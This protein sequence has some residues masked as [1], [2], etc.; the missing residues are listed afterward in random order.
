MRRNDKIAGPIVAR[1]ACWRSYSWGMEMRRRA[2][3]QAAM[4]L[5]GLFLLGIGILL[6]GGGL[7][8]NAATDDSRVAFIGLGLIAWGFIGVTSAF[9]VVQ[10]QF[11]RWEARFEEPRRQTR[12]EIRA[13]V[14]G[15][16]EA[17]PSSQSDSD[18]GTGP[19]STT[20]PCR[21]CGTHNPR[22]ASWCNDCGAEVR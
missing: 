13:S 10:Y 11:G 12:G 18:G 17:A 4:L 8:W 22:F 16:R 1:T 14:A 5:L 21:K 20:V 3:L 7:L 2:M 9:L 19:A 6:L 15:S